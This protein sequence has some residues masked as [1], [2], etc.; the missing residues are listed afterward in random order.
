ML[1]QWCD[2]CVGI[3]NYQLT[4]RLWYLESNGWEVFSITFIRG[5]FFD[6]WQIISRRRQE[7]SDGR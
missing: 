7:A 5:I 4:D 3:S 2:D 1:H 6:K